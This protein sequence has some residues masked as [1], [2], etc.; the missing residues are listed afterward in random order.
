MSLMLWMRSV[1][2]TIARTKNRFRLG[3][4]GTLDAAQGCERRVLKDVTAAARTSK[5][6]VDR[7]SAEPR[8]EGTVC[9]YVYVR[10]C[11]CVNV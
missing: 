2:R 9:V 4:F 7:G 10:V 11:M 8:S 3:A 6:W 1:C 5:W